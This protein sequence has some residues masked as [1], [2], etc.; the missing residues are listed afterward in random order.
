MREAEA[1]DYDDLLLE[2]L[3]ILEEIPKDGPERKQFSYL[4]IDEFQDINPL[5][6]RLVREWGRGGRE[7]FVIG[8]PDQ[9]VYGFRGCDP[10]V[11]SRL[12]EDY[13]ELATV[14]LEEN[15]RSAPEILHTSLGLISHNKGEERRMRARGKGGLPVRM[16]GEPVKSVR[17]GDFQILRY[18]TEPIDRRPCWKSV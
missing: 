15:Y 18:F 12:A 11:F 17:Y 6:Y 14:R 10:E 2:T 4:L 7:L 8:D 16:R 13:P 9:S 1:L 5:Q 3:K